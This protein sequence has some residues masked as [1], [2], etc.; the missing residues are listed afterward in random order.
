LLSGDLSRFLV[1]VLD[2]HIVVSEASHWDVVALSYYTNTLVISLMV[3]SK[4]AGDLSFFRIA[5]ANAMIFT[6][7]NDLDA[8][9]ILVGWIFHWRCLAHSLFPAWQS[10]SFGSITGL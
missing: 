7:V 4:A 5:L 2:V 1:L 3:L 9:L 8:L 6:G 10:P